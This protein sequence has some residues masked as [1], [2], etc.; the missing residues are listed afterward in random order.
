MTYERNKIIALLHRIFEAEDYRWG[1]ENKSPS[2][3]EIEEIVESLEQSAYK[4][5]GIAETGRI[6]VEYDKESQIYNYYL[7]LGM[8]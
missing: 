6:R 1:L 3:K 2:Y 7:Y 8:D 5:K 4:V